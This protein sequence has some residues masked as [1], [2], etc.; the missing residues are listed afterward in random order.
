MKKILIEWTTKSKKFAFIDNK[1]YSAAELEIFK[2]DHP[3][4]DYEEKVLTEKEN[5]D[6]LKSSDLKKA[7]WFNVLKIDMKEARRLGDKYAHKDMKEGRAEVRR[8]RSAKRKDEHNRIYQKMK[9]EAMYLED[10]IRTSRWEEI[11]DI[12]DD[13][14]KAIGSKD[15]SS[16]YGRLGDYPEMW[17]SMGR[18]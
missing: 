13:M 18:Y 11:M 17:P 7:D 4:Y 14:G 16:I 15:F 8:E 5:I 9:K 10:Q 6:R 1:L 3:M 2:D 12:I